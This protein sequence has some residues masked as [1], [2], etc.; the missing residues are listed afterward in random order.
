MRKEIQKESEKIKKLPDFERKHRDFGFVLNV[1][2]AMGR[3]DEIYDFDRSIFENRL[4]E[5]FT[6]YSNLR[7]FEKIF[8]ISVLE[9]QKKMF[10]DYIFLLIDVKGYGIWSAS[11]TPS[12]PVLW[13]HYA[14]NHKGVCLEFEIENINFDSSNE[15]NLIEVKYS[16]M[17]FDLFS[18]DKKSLG[19]LTN[20]IL[21]TKY[22]NW[23]YEQEVR[24]VN[25]KQGLHKFEKTSLKRIIFGYRSEHRDR[26]AICKLLAHLKYSTELFIARAQPDKYE[27]KIERMT[28]HDIVNSGIHFNEMN[29]RDL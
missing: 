15:L 5:I 2:I 6:F 14:N 27:L 19:K 7:F 22:N 13:G 17:P 28:M 21:N 9:L 1:H 23:K 29:L 3:F 8:K 25:S 18:H 26:Y 10:D 4:I 12:C 11:K 24:L 20:K 16:N